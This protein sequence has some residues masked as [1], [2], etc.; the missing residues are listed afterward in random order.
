MPKEEQYLGKVVEVKITSV[1]K[2]FLMGTPL[3]DC[4]AVHSIDVPLALTK[5]K[6]SGLDVGQVGCF[7]LILA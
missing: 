5:G 4:D 3:S 6:V 1:G 2:H 7:F